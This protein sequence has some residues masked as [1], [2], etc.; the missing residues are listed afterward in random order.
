MTLLYYVIAKLYPPEDA[1]QFFLTLTVATITTPLALMGLQAF[2]VK[3]IAALDTPNEAHAAMSRILRVFVKI[4]VPVATVTALIFGFG[5]QPLPISA[6]VVFCL[7]LLL[8]ILHL[9]GSYLQARRLFNSAIFV[10]N[11]AFFALLA[12]LLLALRQL[13][14]FPGQSSMD[15]Q[16]GVCLAALFAVLCASAIVRSKLAPDGKAL[17]ATTPTASALTRQNLSQIVAFWA[18]YGMVALNNWMPQLLYYNFGD[19]VDYAAF[20]VAQ[21]LA[22]IVGF[23]VIISNFMLA[24]YIS[25][26]HSKGQYDELKRMFFKFTGMTTLVALPFA[27]LMI[28]FPDRLL[29]LFGKDYIIGGSYLALLSFVQLINVATG[30]SN[31]FL[32]MT[33]RSRLLL[34][35]MFGSFLAG[36]AAIVFL[37]PIY[38]GWG[39]ALGL[40]TTLVLQSLLTFAAVIW[41]IYKT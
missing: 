25:I 29:G 19:P 7:L 13:D 9:L 41:V 23:F 1:S 8:P 4:M 16:V 38:G 39:F 28:L 3:T 20:S 12:L 30:S 11:I 15:L 2:S 40:A 37:A 34:V 5:W 22:N 10:M 35:I 14:V 6:P 27:G 17:L 32:N 31:V 18:I 33:G 36:M 24:P 21:R 26:Q